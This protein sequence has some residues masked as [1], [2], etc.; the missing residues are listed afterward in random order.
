MREIDVGPH[1]GRVLAAKLEPDAREVPAAA[2]SIAWPA[3]TEPVKQIWS[4]APEP[5]SLVVSSWVSVSVRNRPFGKPALSI[6]V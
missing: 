4:T 1:I 2:R 6:A 3:A 5:I